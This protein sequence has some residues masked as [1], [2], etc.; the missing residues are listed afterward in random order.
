MVRNVYDERGLIIRG[1]TKIS[2]KLH[3]EFGNKQIEFNCFV[4]GLRQRNK[5]YLSQIDN[6]GETA[7][8]F[9]MPH[10]NPIKFKSEKEVTMKITG[11]VKWQ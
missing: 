4:I 7:V 10:N 3:L 11:Y 8:F 6:A 9:D 5:Y 2:Q 1:R